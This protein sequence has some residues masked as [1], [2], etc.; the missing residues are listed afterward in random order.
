MPWTP[1]MF[2]STGTI[3]IKGYFQYLPAI[4]CVLPSLL[5]DI[6]S[7]LTPYRESLRK[8]YSL[9]D[10]THTGFIHVR[11]GDYLAQ[12]THHWIQTEEYYTKGLNQLSTV[13]RWLILS[14]DIEWCREQPFFSHC[15]CLDE[16]DELAG[17]ALMSLCHGGAI[18]ANSTYSWWG[19]M[20]GPEQA[21]AP[22]VY[23]SKWL[24]DA[25]PSLFRETW[26]KV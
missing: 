2:E 26:L 16:T 25:E 14:D 15:E 18:I 1:K 9:M 20:L 11:R 17:L 6:T 8:K 21:K 12:P 5:A 23:P 10:P 22:I 19:A 7:F 24:N 13:S 3:N 4:E